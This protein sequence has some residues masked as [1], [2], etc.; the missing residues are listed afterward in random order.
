MIKPCVKCQRPNPGWDWGSPSPNAFG[1]GLKKGV[2]GFPFFLHPFPSGENKPPVTMIKEISYDN[3][4]HKTG[5]LFAFG[6]YQLRVY[7][8]AIITVEYDYTSFDR[9]DRLI[10]GQD[11]LTEIDWKNSS[12]D[13]L[14]MGVSLVN[15]E[16]ED[17]L[18]LLEPNEGGYKQNQFLDLV[19]E[20]KGTTLFEMIKDAV[21]A[22]GPD[23]N[24]GPN[25]DD[26]W[27]EKLSHDEREHRDEV[28][29]AKYP[30]E[31]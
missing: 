12:I 11:G 19:I 31:I 15:R 25:T 23:Q 6:A 21:E 4:S 14:N 3:G 24:G 26:D 13:D 18:D 5:M 20:E 22:D 16:G 10:M 17:C 7:L 1:L 27:I 30:E 2:D 29:A 8:S 9:E 28:E